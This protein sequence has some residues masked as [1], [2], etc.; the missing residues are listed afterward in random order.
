M[1]PPGAGR[2]EASPSG[3]H[4]D[5]RGHDPRGPRPGSARP[6]ARPGPPGCCAARPATR[7]GPGPPCWRC[8]RRPR[9]STR[10]A[11]AATAGPTT[12]TP[13]RSRPAPRAG[14][15][16]SSARSTPS[17]FITVDKTPAS[18]WVMD[19][20]ARIFGLNSWSVLVP[21]ALEGV[22]T[23]GAAV[24]HGPALVRPGGRASSPAPCL[25]LTPV[26]ALMF[27]FNNPDALLVLLMTAAA[28]ARDPG[29]RVRAGPAG[30]CWPGPRSGFG[31]LTKMLQAF[32]V[33]PGVRAGLPGGRAAPAGPADLAAAGRRG[34]PGGWPRAGGWRSCSSPRPPT[35]PTS[36]APP[37][38]ACCSSRSA[39]TASAGS[40]G[41]ET[42]SVGGSGGG[43]GGARSAAQP[44]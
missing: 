21:Q 43:G 44:G 7:A 41:N 14:R 20:S 10:S 19:L 2:T 22:A 12:S 16:S 36:A 32:L 40:T 27:R 23:V 1:T 24:R 17:N 5:D 9:C 3:G 4:H 39:T 13:P 11:S 25:A 31:F 34:G 42:G 35:G 15:R 26:A 37:T 29:H 6:A 28:Y 33:L 18:L 8:S 30:S 38:T